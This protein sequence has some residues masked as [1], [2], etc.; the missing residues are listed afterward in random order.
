MV[1]IMAAKKTKPPNTPNAIMPP[2]NIKSKSEW[3]F[4]LSMGPIVYFI[5]CRSLSIDINEGFTFS[6]SLN[7]TF[8]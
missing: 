7:G 1:V 4:I 2:E 5:E 6:R 8:P 3:Y